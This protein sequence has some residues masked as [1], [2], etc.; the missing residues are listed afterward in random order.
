MSTPDG[1]ICSIEGDSISKKEHCF[2]KQTNPLGFILFSRNYSNK[3]Q[4]ID[5]INLDNY[6]FHNHP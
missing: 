3:R 2:F 1:I 5:L 4:I 6:H